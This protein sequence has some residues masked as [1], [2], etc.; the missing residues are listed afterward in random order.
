[1]TIKG[2][3]VLSRD[4][5]YITVP[6]GAHGVKTLKINDPNNIEVTFEKIEHVNSVQMYR[7]D[8]EFNTIGVNG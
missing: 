8:G 1:M 7:F 3:F 4:Y 5:N 2:P 6:L